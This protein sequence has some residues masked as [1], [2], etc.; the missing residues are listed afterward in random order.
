MVWVGDRDLVVFAGLPGAGKS[1]ALRAL[2]RPPETMVLD[3]ETVHR[4]VRAVAGGRLAYRSYRGMVH[5]IHHLR[6]LRAAFTAAKVVVVH[7]PTTRP[8][9]RA[10]LAA[11][12]FVTGR[13][14]VLVWLDVEP[15]VARAGQ[16]ARGRAVSPGSFRKHMRRAHR[17]R[18]GLRAGKVPPGWREVHVFTRDDLG[19]GL[20]VRS[21]RD[22]ARPDPRSVRELG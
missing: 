10:S 16:R 1:T 11:L 4:R 18:A 7:E 9:V 22:I 12:G 8:L 3:S 2:I 20:R 5:L 19:D 15:V 17:L 13:R 21:V 6:I 14:L